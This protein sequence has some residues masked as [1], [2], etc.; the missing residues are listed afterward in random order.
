MTPERGLFD[1][2][3]LMEGVERRFL[4]F[5]SH[6]SKCPIK[7]GLSSVTWLE[8]KTHCPVDQKGY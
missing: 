3:L 1:D 5:V 7:F 6:C 8:G 4:L 2:E